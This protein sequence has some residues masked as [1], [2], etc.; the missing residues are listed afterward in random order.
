[1]QLEAVRS[2]VVD[3][4]A[5]SGNRADTQAELAR[6]QITELQ[7]IVEA[8]AGTNAALTAGHRALWDQLDAL[9]ARV[10]R[11]LDNAQLDAVSP[12]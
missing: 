4:S 1:M 7:A 5:T 8:Q 6:A 11:L 3:L 9:N 2:S 10:Q 12:T